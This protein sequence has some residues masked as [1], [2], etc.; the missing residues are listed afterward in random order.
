M[1]CFKRWFKV[2]SVTDVADWGRWIH[3]SIIYTSSFQKKTSAKDVLL[4]PCSNESLGV[5]NI[6]FY[7]VLEGAFKGLGCPYGGPRSISG[8]GA[9]KE[10]G[11]ERLE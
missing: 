8:S 9:R 3:K 4:F 7:Y 2:T 5:P 10:K 11:G 1:E 6:Y